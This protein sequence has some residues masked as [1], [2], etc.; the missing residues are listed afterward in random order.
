M[1]IAFMCTIFCS[2]KIRAGP[3]KEAFK[4][5]NIIHIKTNGKKK[6]FPYKCLHKSNQHEMSRMNFV[7]E[8]PKLLKLPV[9]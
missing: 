7:N 9:Q 8:G 6:C 3:K 5:F 2:I 1:L 4:S